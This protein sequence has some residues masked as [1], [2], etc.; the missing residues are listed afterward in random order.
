MYLAFTLPIFDFGVAFL[1]IVFM[2]FFM[3]VLDFRI[4]DTD[5]KSIKKYCNNLSVLF[6]LKGVFA[7]LALLGLSYVFPSLELALR[8]SAMVSFFMSL[9][10]T[11][12]V[13]YKLIGQEVKVYKSYFISQVVLVI[14]V[15]IALYFSNTYVPVIIGYSLFFAVLMILLWKDFP[16]K[17]KPKVNKIIITKIVNEWKERF[18][19]RSIN[20]LLE[21]GL[22][23]YVALMYGINEFA[24]VYFILLISNFF[25][26]RVTI[27]FSRMFKNKFENIS[28][29]MF[30]LNMVRIIEYIAFIS[31]P[32]SVIFFSFSFEFGKLLNYP[33]FFEIIY[34]FM[35]AGLVKTLF[36]TGR[37]AL[38]YEKKEYINQRIMV[39]ELILLLIL[40]P[41]L[42]VMFGLVGIAIGYFI[43]SVFSSLLYV[44][45]AERITKLNLITV[46]RDYFYIF[47]S[48]IISSI[49]IAL[50]KEWYPIRNIWT[51]LIYG[52]IGLAIYVGLTFLLNQ[53]LYK[54]FTRFMFD[55]LD[56][57]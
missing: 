27:F 26:R 22:L 45:L 46:S 5:Q 39:F 48:A 1:S 49:L 8:L 2:Y 31:V 57:E 43:A 15:S 38:Q 28:Y 54:R 32:L 16:Y 30:K 9:K 13:Y 14:T 23:I 51:V 36:E 3:Y 10:S 17:L 12:E 33:R 29:D 42:N 50:I 53:D 11:P 18:F 47:F 20:N 6:P 34:I 55:I 52:L 56:E 19:N 25:Y 21:Y 4:V 44:L 40:V 35:I 24:T 37:I 7:G 41:I